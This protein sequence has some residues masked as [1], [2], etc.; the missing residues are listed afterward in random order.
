MILE[1]MSFGIDWLAA[2]ITLLVNI[3]LRSE[4]STKL[5]WLIKVSKFILL[6]HFNII[7][8]LVENKGTTDGSM[9]TAH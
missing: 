1:V 5:I 9:V 8:L 2:L 7:E 3:S 6:S 4:T